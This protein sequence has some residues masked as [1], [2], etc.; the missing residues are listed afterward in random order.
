MDSSV[1][2]GLAGLGTVGAQVMRSLQA[3]ALDGV[4]VTMVCVRDLTKPRDV[5]LSDVIVTND[6]QDLVHS[7]Q[8]DII[9]E[10]IGGE[11][12]VALELVR[13]ALSS[14]KAVVTANKAM[15]ARH[16]I[17]L[18]LLA[19]QSGQPLAYEAAVAGGIPIIKTIR[20][21][22]IGNTI[23]R[24]SGILNGTCN[25]MLTEMA[26]T[27]GSF[28]LILKQAQDLG[29][30]EADPS[31]DINGI[32]AAQKLTLLASLAFGVKPD[33]DRVKYQ[34]IA[35]IKAR[36]IRAAKD[37]NCQIRL[38]ARAERIG[39][40]IRLWVG[41]A[42]LR[43]SHPLADIDGVTNAVLVSADPVGDLMLVGPGAGGGATASAVLSDIADL[44]GGYGRSLFTYPADQLTSID[45][46]HSSPPCEWYLRFL[47]EDRAGSMARITQ[48][49]AEN[50]VSI[51]EIIQRA[52]SDGESH[53][54][55]VFITHSAEESLI[56]KAVEEI[57][58]LGDMAGEELC[59]PVFAK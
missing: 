55:V 10:L 37:F 26:E 20:E 38:I 14:G 3:G 1:R 27:G 34:G 4:K 29:Y 15:L 16:A 53:L 19:E 58:K 32:D 17:E 47:L 25:Y 51:E 13:G 31:F 35:Q 49:L 18:A 50:G 52:P 9:V 12:G 56:A 33:L 48:I 8:I 2:V 57:R 39:E 24:L 59:L 21:S 22:L 46:R 7:D 6:P 11:N 28:D 41:P 23:E 43:Q 40:G 5:D 54:P 44:A 45:T 42:L 36:D 30:A